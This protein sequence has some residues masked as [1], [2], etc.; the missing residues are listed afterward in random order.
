MD[1]KKFEVPDDVSYMTFAEASTGNAVGD[2]PFY[3]LLNGKVIKVTWNNQ[4]PDNNSHPYYEIIK[5]NAGK[6]LELL[7]STILYDPKY[8]TP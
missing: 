4:E 2:A 8:G 5:K 1:L 3:L 7:L 6:H